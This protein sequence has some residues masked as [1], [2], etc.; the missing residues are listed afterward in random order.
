[1]VQFGRAHDRC[2]DPRVAEQPDESDLRRWHAAC[3]GTAPDR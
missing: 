3:P 2:G 1:V